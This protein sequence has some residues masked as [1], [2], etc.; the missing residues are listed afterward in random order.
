LY[1]TFPWVEDNDTK[2]VAWTTTPWTLPS[3]LALVVHPDFDYVKVFDKTHNTHFV[4]AE[5]RLT[6]LYHGKTAKDYEIKSKFKGTELAGKEYIPL[7]DYFHDRKADGCFRVLVDPYV[8]S[9]TGTG[10]VHAAPGFGADDYRA[11]VKAGII[12]PDNPPVPIDENG[13]FL[14]II[15]DFA[16]LPVKEA[17]KEVRKLLRHNGRLLI[18]S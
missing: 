6:E 9:D 8:T 16:G 15:K 1:I 3:N 11:C 12:R 18:D 2:F 7:F 10:V 13:R 5:C 17:D 4:F 14:P